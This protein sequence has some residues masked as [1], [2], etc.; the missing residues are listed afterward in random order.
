MSPNTAHP[1][2]QGQRGVTLV[3]LIVSIVIVAT[4]VGAILNVLSSNLGRSADAFITLQA[5]AGCDRVPTPTVS[6]VIPIGSISTISM[7]TMAWLITALE[8][9]SITQLPDS[10]TT[11]ST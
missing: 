5:G 9:S 2:R 11:A 4:A 10:T 6:T 7:T 1:Q 8:T 3:E